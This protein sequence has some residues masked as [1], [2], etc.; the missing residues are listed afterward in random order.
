[1][2]L[3]YIVKF[4]FSILLFQSCITA[5]T[6]TIEQAI[7]EESA[8]KIKTDEGQ[9]YRF[10]E[11]IGSDTV[12]YGLKK[13][14]GGGLV[15][16]D[17]THLNIIHIKYPYPPDLHSRLK[18]IDFQLE[19]GGYFE[20]YGISGADLNIQF[21]WTHPLTYNGSL[22]LHFGAGVDIWSDIFCSDVGYVLA[23]ALSIG[24]KHRFEFGADFKHYMLNY[25]Y[26]TIAPAKFGYRLIGRKMTYRLFFAPY[27]NNVGEYEN[28]MFVGGSLSVKLINY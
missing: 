25:N 17:I 5:K 26:W 12:L 28:S 18:S 10:E 6:V 20:S 9:T 4:L 8:V 13:M 1:M 2:K 27:V 15:V 19:T 23:P 16:Q 11:L 7:L 24:R 3:Q 21:V 14:K 22:A